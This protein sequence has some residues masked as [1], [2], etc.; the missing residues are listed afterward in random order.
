MIKTNKEWASRGLLFVQQGSSIV[1]QDQDFKH[2][3]F[4]F[5]PVFLCSYDIVFL[6][7]LFA[8]FPGYLLLSCQSHSPFLSLFAFFF[9]Q[10]NEDGSNSQSLPPQTSRVDDLADPGTADSVTSDPFTADNSTA[11]CGNC[12]TVTADP[13]NPVWSASGMRQ[14]VRMEMKNLI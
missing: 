4:T 12:D 9:T 1:T 7:F 14:S 13:T 5:L 11:D 3:S 8:F 6:I 10:R 2:L